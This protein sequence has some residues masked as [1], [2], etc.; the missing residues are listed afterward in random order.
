M[1]IP[2]VVLQCHSLDHG[3]FLLSTAFIPRAGVCA[4]G[5]CHETIPALLFLSKLW[6]T[7]QREEYIN[8]Y[9]QYAWLA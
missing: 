9:M 3:P 6:Q 1:Q 2:Y 5:H 4:L 7:L 8:M